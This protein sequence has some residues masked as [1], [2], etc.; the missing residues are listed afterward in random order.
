MRF[1]T[2]FT[3]LSLVT[4]VAGIYVYTYYN[5]VIGPDFRSYSHALEQGL[6]SF[7]LREYVS[8]WLI[9]FFSD[10]FDG[11]RILSGIIQ[12]SL[13]YSIIILSVTINKISD[14]FDNRLYIMWG[15]VLLATFNPFTYLLSIS[16]LR[17]GIG[18]SFFIFA[19][20][21]YYRKSLFYALPFFVAS[22]FSHNSML[23]FF[24]SFLFFMYLYQLNKELKIIAA[25]IGLLI[26]QTVWIPTADLV[27]NSNFLLYTLSHA[28]VL[29]YAIYSRSPELKKIVYMALV[30]SLGFITDLSYY[31]RLSLFSTA[32]M[33]PLVIADMYSRV[34]PMIFVGFAFLPFLFVFIFVLKRFEVSI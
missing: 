17:Q 21:F 8:W 32:L 9:S 25:V 31:D 28:I 29:S 1:T 7:M 2:L 23:L 18:A 26:L 13:C 10:S 3:V 14:N 34:R 6:L 20:V 15:L 19:V 22:I 30:P 11:L 12:F 24:V 4:A 27:T 16:A 33:W 5:R